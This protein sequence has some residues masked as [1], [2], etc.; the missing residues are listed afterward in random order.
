MTY[1]KKIQAVALALFFTLT[2]LPAA[3]QTC[4]SLSNG[5]LVCYGIRRD[6]PPPPPL[7]SR[8]RGLTWEPSY[9]GPRVPDPVVNPRFEDL[10]VFLRPGN[11]GVPVLTSC[12]FIFEPTP[13]SA[14]PAPR[15]GRG[16]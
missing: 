16:K 7:E 12:D 14:P 15:R 11:F 8:V 1:V 10:R 9:A 13:I 4:V 6:P 5:R 3:A 2:S